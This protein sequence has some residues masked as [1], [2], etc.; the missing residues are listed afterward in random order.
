L[1]CLFVASS[2]FAP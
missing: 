2:H 1:Y